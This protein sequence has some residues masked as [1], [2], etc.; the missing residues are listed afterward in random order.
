MIKGFHQ[1]TAKCNLPMT[2]NGKKLQSITYQL[3][4]YSDS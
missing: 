1:V 4:K 2:F 3:K